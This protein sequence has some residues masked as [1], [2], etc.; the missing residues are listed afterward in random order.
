MN[1]RR[2]LVASSNLDL[3]RPAAEFLASAHARGAGEVVVL[4]PSRGAADDFAR[5]SVGPGD[6]FLGIHSLTL[7]QIAAHL[8]AAPLAASGLTPMSGLSQDA[9]TARVVHTLRREGLLHYFDPVAGTPGF[10]GCLS[11]TIAELRMEEAVLPGPAASRGV[12]SPVRDLALLTQAWA[13]QL[14]QQSLAD[15]AQLFRIATSTASHRYLGLPVLV[16]DAPLRGSLRR[17]LMAHLVASAPAVFVVALQSDTASVA[18]WRQLLEVE[19]EERADI[20][21]TVLA[22]ARR[23]LFGAALSEKR[24]PDTTLEMFSAAGDSLECVEIAR[25][26]RLA[27]G[28]GFAFDQMAILLRSP[29]R[30][31][32][33]VEEALRRAGI[34]AWFHRGTA[35]PD[36][37]GRAFLALLQCAMEDCSASR[38]SEY[39]SL[40]Q[41]PE[42]DAGGAPVRRERYRVAVQDEVLASFE[43]GSD[44]GPDTAFDPEL[45]P[46][47]SFAAP[48]AWER[49]LVDAAVVGGPDRWE[50]RLDGLDRE[51]ALQIAGL[52]DE[53]EA[54]RAAIERRAVQLRLLRGFA[55]PVVKLLDALSRADEPGGMTWEVWIARLTG[56][57]ETALRSPESV[58]AVLRELRPMA[59]VG[60]VQLVEVH[61][62]L[63]ERLRFLRNDPPTRRYGQV[64][65]AGVDQARGRQ[66]DTVFLPGLAEG[67]FP[68]RAQED[69]LLL[70]AHR[71][72][73]GADLAVQDTRV[74][75]ERLLLRVAA[76]AGSRLVVSYPRIDVA[77]SRPR[78]P[79]FYALE[80]LRAA[81]GHL[82]DLREFEQRLAQ[83]A[84]SRLGWPAP[85]DPGE[86][87]DDAEYDLAVLDRLLGAEPAAVT[88][89]GRFLVEVN[90]ALARSLRA[91]WKR[92]ADQWSDADGIVGPDETARAALNAHRL[93]ARPYSATALQQ[94][95]ACPYK[96]LLYAIHR[97]RPRESSEPLEQMDPLTRGALF[98]EIQKELV[99]GLRARG[100]TPLDRGRLDEALEL[101]DSILDRA[102]ARYAEELAPAIP[103]VWS[104]EV[105]DLRG[106]LRGWLRQVA[107]HDS[108][109]EP[110]HT[111]YEFNGLRVAERVLLRG[112]IDLIE[113]KVG[114]GVLRVTDHKTG[115]Q[116]EQRPAYVGG[117]AVLQP[118]LY[119]LVAEQALGLPVERGRLY[120][121]T[122]RG[123][124][125]ETEIPFTDT[126]RQRIA[127]VLDIVDG[128]I[129]EG[130]LPAAPNKDHC[131][132][133]DYEMV[134][135]PYEAQRVMRKPS[136]RLRSL[137]E[138][139]GL[140]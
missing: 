65:V 87:L 2:L 38:F 54:T 72:G 5:A 40:A 3:H 102:A 35:R 99:D 95:A 105:D 74:A 28:R 16:L 49:L 92:W 106:D 61:A 126:A 42:L 34:P 63:R 29:E 111:E 138:L 137:V 69:P 77:Q 10:I 121:C 57:A 132:I 90:T 79:S 64:F 53:D 50:R 75:E 36:P 25:R 112:A 96:F 104:S 37:A 21:G 71:S 88:G 133:C 48:A 52:R 123:G 22:R 122:Q 110:L 136:G 82:P 100:L 1:G 47:P 41:V 70:D 109:W 97:L 59:T 80:L 55:I 134:C 98:H 11:R 66:F 32:P 12:A 85:R 103:R 7:T 119:S 24:K 31:Q 131:E 81:E 27:A 83:A 15:L 46:A 56:L 76:A 18:A 6:G 128:A 127:Q 89:R 62:V 39:L 4:A 115:K 19:P 101:A 129:D 94:Y 13:D 118:L 60:P 86:A 58:V 91:R 14:R 67:L 51:I 68:R 113:R 8:A 117:G 124:F 84:P 26:I 114:E 116:P 125:D 135:G 45:E 140:P 43:P 139:R 44:P 9:L 107:I 30:Y 20:S 108:E 17:K 78:V 93:A 130:F 33:L 73:L 120:Y 23:H